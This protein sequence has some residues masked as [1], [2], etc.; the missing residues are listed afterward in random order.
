MEESAVQVDGHYQIALPWKSDDRKLSKNRQIIKRQLNSLK[1]QFVRNPDFFQLYCEKLADYISNGYAR[2]IS[3]DSLVSGT[4]LDGVPKEDRLGES[5]IK[6]RWG[7]H[8]ILR[9]IVLVLNL[10]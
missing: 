6:A 1:Q 9:Q 3:E 4:V 10:S 7:Y 8:G 5:D 2:K